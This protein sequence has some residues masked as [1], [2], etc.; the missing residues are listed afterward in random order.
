MM[1]NA[2]SEQALSAVDPSQ[3]KDNQFQAYNI[4]TWHLKQNLAGRNPPPL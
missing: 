4:I 3:L 2:T 1:E